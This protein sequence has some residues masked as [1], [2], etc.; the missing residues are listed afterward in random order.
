MQLSLQRP[1]WSIT[2]TQKYVVIV[3]G[4]LL[5]LQVET[6]ERFLETS[7]FLQVVGVPVTLSGDLKNQ[8][9]WNN[10]RFWYSVQGEY[11]GIYLEKQQF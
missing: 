2:A 11:Y 9:C 6:R 3:F 1:L 5:I 8:F 7:P 4:M 10:C